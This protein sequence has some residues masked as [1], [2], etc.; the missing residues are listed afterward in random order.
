VR[1]D[2]GVATQARKAD[3]PIEG[4]GIGA[5]LAVLGTVITVVGLVGHLGDGWRLGLTVTG[6]V[7]S[8]FGLT[9]VALELAKLRD[10]PSL[11]DVGAAAACLAI[12]ATA[13]VSIRSTMLPTW[14]NVVLWVV[15]ALLGGVGVVG[16]SK[17]LVGYLAESIEVRSAADLSTKNKRGNRPRKGS[18]GRQPLSRGEL[19]G[20]I[21]AVVSALLGPAATILAEFIGKGTGPTP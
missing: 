14:A 9:G 21:V 13:F 11:T 4:L 5:G 8:G 7:F 6:L 3:S 17:G 10:R 15:V 20:L 18:R 16:S 1:R 2:V 19:L 12:A